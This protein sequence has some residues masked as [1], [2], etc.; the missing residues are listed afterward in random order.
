MQVLCA[1]AIGA[2]LGHVYPGLDEDMKPLGDGFIKLIKMLIAPVI[3][4]AA[5]HGIAGVEDIKKVGRVG[6]KALVYFEAPTAAALVIGLVVVNLCKPGVGMNVDARSVEARTAK[7]AEQ[8]MVDC[9]LHI[10]PN[11]V[12]GAFAEGGIL[13]VLLFAALFAFGL[14]RLGARESRC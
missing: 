1:I 8:G 5:V 9:L 7:A 2:L 12:V 10:I 6:V 11:A 4:C 3:F 14:H 13:Q